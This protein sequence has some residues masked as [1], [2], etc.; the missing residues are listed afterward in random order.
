[1]TTKDLLS[2]PAPWPKTHRSW[3]ARLIPTYL[4]ELAKS[5]VYYESRIIN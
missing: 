4:E 5:G 3:N 1:M 2:V